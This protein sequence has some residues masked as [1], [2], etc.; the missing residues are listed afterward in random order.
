LIKNNI[1]SFAIEFYKIGI[2][3]A[4]FLPDVLYKKQQV[5]NP[6]KILLGHQEPASFVS[7]SG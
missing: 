7:A 4:Y 6:Y 5:L 3:I 1:F 2:Y